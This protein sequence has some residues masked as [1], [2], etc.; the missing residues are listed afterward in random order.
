MRTIW[1]AINGA[2]Y[3]YADWIAPVVLILI[4]LWIIF[5]IFNPNI[6]ND[7]KDNMIKHCEQRDAVTYCT[8]WK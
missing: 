6:I 5:S 7:I 1:T 3:D 2:C 4:L 8:I